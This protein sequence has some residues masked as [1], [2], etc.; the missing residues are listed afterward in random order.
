VRTTHDM[1]SEPSRD[2]FTRLR[3]SPDPATDGLTDHPLSPR[4]QRAVNDVCSRGEAAPMVSGGSLPAAC[5]SA[6]PSWRPSAVLGRQAG[7]AKA[8]VRQLTDTALQGA[9]AS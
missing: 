2:G 8:V 4:R 7:L 6:P 3:R 1:V 5:P 9:N